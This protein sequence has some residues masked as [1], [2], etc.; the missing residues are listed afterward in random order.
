MAKNEIQNQKKRL[1]DCFV[2]NPSFY[3]SKEFNGVRAHISEKYYNDFQVLEKI[4]TSEK[5]RTLLSSWNLI[6]R[7]IDEVVAGRYETNS[8]E[9]CDDYFFLLNRFNLH[10]DK[11]LIH[12]VTIS[13]LDFLVFIIQVIDK[14][15]VNSEKL[16]DYLI[17]IESLYSF[18]ERITRKVNLKNVTEQSKYKAL[19]SR[20]DQ[21][22]NFDNH[23]NASTW[24][25][26]YF[27]FRDK[28]KFN[29]NI[30]NN[31]LSNVSVFIRNSSNPK[32]LKK[33]IEEV[34][35]IQ[36]FA[37]TTYSNEIYNKC[38]NSAQFTVEFFSIFDEAKKQILL[39]SW[40]QKNSNQVSSLTK[41][42]KEEI[43]NKKDFGNKILARANTLNN[44]LSEKKGFYDI[45]FELDISKEEILQSDYT[46]QIKNVVFSTNLNLHNFGIKELKERREF[47][48]T[49]SLKSNAETFIKSYLGNPNTYNVHIQNIIN[50]KLGLTTAF[51]DNHFRSNI[52]I[53]NTVNTYLVQTGNYKFYEALIS[54][55]TKTTINT[56]NEKFVISISK[57][58][59]YTEIVNKIKDFYINELNNEVQEK[60]KLLL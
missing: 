17:Q 48:N 12:S 46:I 54:K 44:N 21:V 27:Y 45:L 24:F 14:N 5:T 4:S 19:F 10:E 26:F 23:K 30:E 42:L 22:F 25:K 16:D 60:L 56:I 41:S 11:F 35:S 55:L 39:D 6:Q 43:P 8:V 59:K 18:F 37:S 7:I 51:V 31:V 29:S 36:E 40:I 47:I 53:L 50:N 58:T 34:I 33:V 38:K 2:E 9:P 20:I 32:L 3:S 15:I 57:Q 52:S 13:S 1:L 49:K 28:K